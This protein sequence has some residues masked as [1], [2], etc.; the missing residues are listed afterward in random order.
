M[1]M[2]YRKNKAI[3]SF[4]WAW[5]KYVLRIRHRVRCWQ[6]NN[7]PTETAQFSQSTHSDV[8]TENDPIREKHGRAADKD[9]WEE[10]YAR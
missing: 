5:V 10:N 6:D 1:T 7:E 2:S 3:Q 4:N 9:G 8:E